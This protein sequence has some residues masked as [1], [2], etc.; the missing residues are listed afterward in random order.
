MPAIKT[1]FGLNAEG[2]AQEVLGPLH[3]LATSVTSDK[4]IGATSTVSPK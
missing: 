3:P 4:A 1:T 2:G